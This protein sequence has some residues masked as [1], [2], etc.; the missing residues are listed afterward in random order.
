MKTLTAKQLYSVLWRWHFYAGIFAVPFV[1]ILA[2]TGA[3]YLFKPQI[4][5]FSSAPYRGLSITGDLATADAQVEAALAAVPGATFSAYELPLGSTDAATILVIKNFQTMR[6]YVHPQSLH[7]LAIA[8]EQSPLL[9]YARDIHRELLLGKFGS[10]LV[11]LAACWAIVL[12]LTGVYLWWPRSAKGLAG[13]LYPRV[14]FKG[15][16]F[17]RDLHSVIG[18]WISFFVLFLLISGLPWAF[19][20]GNALNQVRELTHTTATKQDW[21][22]AGQHHHETISQTAL[23]S[24]YVNDTPKL[25]LDAIIKNAEQL[26]LNHPVLI[27]PP[28]GKSGAPTQPWI[29]QSATNWTISSTTQNRTL[30]V[31]VELDAHTGKLLSKSDFS[32]KHIID[33]AVG[34]GISAH[35]GQLFGWLNQLLGLLTAIGLI[36]LSISGFTMW[37]KRAPANVLGAPPKVHDAKLGLGFLIIIGTAAIL[38][39]ALGISLIVLSILEFLVLSRFTKIKIWLGLA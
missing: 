11:E 10:I 21:V 37:R 28:I 4:D 2:A 31:D 16:L 14:T 39:P 23:P 34:I 13:V 3:I 8:D 24:T 18:I 32:D 26:H 12:V 9:R 6:V 36:V 22:I 1:I 35:E 20:W 17:W 19:V 33:R 30:N 5:A 25:P 27:R 38:L 7:V 15:R 29:K